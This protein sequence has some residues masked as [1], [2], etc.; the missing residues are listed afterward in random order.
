[1]RLLPTPSRSLRSPPKPENSLMLS[2]ERRPTSPGDSLTSGSRDT[3]MTLDSSREAGPR[4]LLRP[5][6]RLNWSLETPTCPQGPALSRSHLY[7]PSLGLSPSTGQPTAGCATILLTRLLTL[8]VPSGC[9]SM[10]PG[11]PSVSEAICAK[12]LAP[13]RATA[14]LSTATA[15]MDA[16]AP[17]LSLRGTHGASHRVP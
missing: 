9:M 14:S 12:C 6:P 3:L 10:A 7:P 4:P 2:S 17:L 1:M 16:T 15:S 13:T 5:Q 11:L 8:T